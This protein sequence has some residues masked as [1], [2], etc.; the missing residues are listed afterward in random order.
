VEIARHIFV[1]GGHASVPSRR[2]APMRSTASTQAPLAVIGSS[3]RSAASL[4]LPEKH[5]SAH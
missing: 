1:G 5:P 4:V 2:Q 3:R